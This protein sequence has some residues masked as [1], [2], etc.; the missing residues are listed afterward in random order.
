MSLFKWLSETMEAQK[1]R[2]Q[3]KHL[4]AEAEAKRAAADNRAKRLDEAERTE[5]NVF[6]NCQEC[7]S[8]CLV[9]AHPVA[10]GTSLM[11]TQAQAMSLSRY[12]EKCNIAICGA[13]TGVS[14]QA[15]PYIVT[16]YPCPR[17]GGNTIWTA[18]CH[19]RRTE[20]GLVQ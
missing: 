17:C 14:A 15:E 16:S 6:I 18:V 2:I 7:G 3:A 10:P 5:K 4:A 9:Q 1:K 11:I 12:C 20:A 19:L 13:C 8:R